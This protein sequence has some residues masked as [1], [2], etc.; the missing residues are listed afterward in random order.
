MVM[1]ADN[2]FAH[3]STIVPSL[4]SFR[5]NVPSPETLGNEN[6]VA[7]AIVGM[8]CGNGARG[9]AGCDQGEVGDID[10]GNGFVEVQYEYERIIIGWSGADGVGGNG[11]RGIVD[12]GGV[13]RVGVARCAA[14]CQ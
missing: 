14:S 9:R 3:A 8:N 11:R 2:V 4:L 5:A 6:P 1:P 12:R 13:D 10:A 7:Q